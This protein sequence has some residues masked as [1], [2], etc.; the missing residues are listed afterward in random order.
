MTF[1]LHS[2]DSRAVLH[3]CGAE[4]DK[5]AH[6]G[7]RVVASHIAIHR[8]C[9]EELRKIASVN[10]SVVGLYYGR[11]LDQAYIDQMEKLG[12][13]AAGLL[14]GFAKLRQPLTQ[15]GARFGAKL[16][17]PLAAMGSRLSNSAIARNPMLRRG[18]AA[19]QR[20]ASKAYTGT[21]N[22]IKSPTAK[23]IARSIK[24]EAGSIATSALSDPTAYAMGVTS[25]TAWNALGAAG[26]TIR[27][28]AVSA[29][30]KG[31]LKPLIRGPNGKLMAKNPA[32]RQTLHN[33]GKAMEHSPT[34]GYLGE[35]ALKTF[36]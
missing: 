30:H 23:N 20:P 31:V 1:R 26:R 17:T 7:E 8:A 21:V 33:V 9:T 13:S 11:A 32:V 34:W 24:T 2:L 36:M 27:Q 18:F 15:F 6:E 4:L 29:S 28:R 16:K 22:A 5:I 19:I 25:P 35:T 3:A 14:S 12:F 10:D